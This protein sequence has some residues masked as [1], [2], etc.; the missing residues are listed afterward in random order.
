MSVA[1][2][3][4]PERERRHVSGDFHGTIGGRI[5]VRRLAASGP[6]PC[7]DSGETGPCRGAFRGSGNHEYYSGAARWTEKVGSLGF[8]VLNNEHRLLSLAG[9]R[10]LVA[11]VTDYQAGARMPGQRS[12]HQKAIAGDPTADVKIL[13]AHQPK[14][15]FAA[16]SAGFDL[17]ISGHTHGGQFFPWN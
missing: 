4:L 2:V 6:E 11:A 8:E 12:D 16:A 7:T 15:A 13:L 1:I 9:G 5:G 10:I 3:G 14:S 17:Q